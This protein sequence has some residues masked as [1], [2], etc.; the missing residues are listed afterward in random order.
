MHGS[1]QVEL[2]VLRVLNRRYGSLACAS[3]RPISATR[4]RMQRKTAAP[5]WRDVR[6]LMQLLS[7]P[8]EIWASERLERKRTVLKLTFLEELAYSRNEGLRTPQLTVPFTLFGNIADFEKMAERK[9]F[10]P[11]IRLPVCRISSAVLSTTQPPLRCVV[12]PMRVAGAVL[13]TPR[14]GN[15]VESA[16]PTLTCDSHSLILR[17]SMA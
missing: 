17:L 6:T 7:N 16:A 12:A 5:L 13:T 14:G 9:G 2:Q 8:C 4:E 3:S 1:V 10:E 11:P 15:Q